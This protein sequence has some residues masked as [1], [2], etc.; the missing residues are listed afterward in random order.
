[1]NSL[2]TAYDLLGRQEE[3]LKLREATFAKRKA[4]L[5]RSPVIGRPQDLQRTSS[6]A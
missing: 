4:I 6:H 2:G 1:M 5:G 3:A